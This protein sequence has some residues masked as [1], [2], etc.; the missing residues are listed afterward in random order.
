MKK[1]TLFETGEID[2]W[3]NSSVEIPERDV[4]FPGK[5]FLKDALNLTSCEIS[6]NSLKPGEG[7]PF[8]HS[9]IRNEEVYVFLKGEGEFQVDDDLFTV[10]AGSTLR[11]SPEGERAWRNTGED[12]LVFLVVQAENNSLQQYT[13]E[14][15]NIPERKLKWA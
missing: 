3:K 13:A 14:D 4:V 2:T 10:R 5:R 7:M 12:D 15:A 6:L 9:H 11:V 8:C 1:Y